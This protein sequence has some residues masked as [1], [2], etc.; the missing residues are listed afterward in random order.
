MAI[1]SITYI[2]IFILVTLTGL[3]QDRFQISSDLYYTEVRDSVY[4]ITHH[5]PKY[6]SNS[7]FVLL[8]GEQGVLI[9][10]PHETTGTRFLLSWIR[11]KFGKL[12]LTAI[13]TGW[14]QDNLGGNEFLLDRKIPV[15]GPTLTATI[16]QDRGNELKDL[17][18]EQTSSLEDDRYYQSFSELTLLPPN[19]TFAIEEGLLLEK[20]GET[21][22]VYF[23]GESH[24]VDNTVV[25]LHS[26]KILF[27]GCMIMSIRHQQPG[28]I[29]HANMAEW[30]ESVKKVQEKFPFCNLVIPGHGP[31]GNKKLLEHTRNILEAYNKQFPPH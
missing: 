11:T 29:D 20:G 24:T 28:F 14:H 16:L 25:F 12:Q 5:F 17:L 3:S 31:Y 15:Y 6:G 8:P 30:P 10:T 27:G 4:V 26:K 21:F 2:W 18:L 7:L 1:R 9:D 19:H 13:N 22:E 23:P